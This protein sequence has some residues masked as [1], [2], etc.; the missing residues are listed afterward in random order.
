MATFDL[1]I[2]IPVYN[3]EAYLLRTLDSAAAQS[4]RNFRLI[5]VDNNS[6]DSSPDI[7][8]KFKA[9]NEAADFAVDVISCPTPGAAAARNAGLEIAETEWVYFFDS[10]D[11]MRPDL[12]KKF[13]VCKRNTGAD[14]LFLK[15]THHNPDGSSYEIAPPK[16]NLLENHILHGC[17][18]TMGYLVKRSFVNACGG[19]NA[20]VLGWNDWEL[21]MRLLVAHPEFADIPG[22]SLVDYYLHSDSITGTD[23]SSKLN[24]WL[25]AID[26]SEAVI[27]KSAGSDMN[28]MLLLL[29]YKRIMLAGRCKYEGKSNGDVLYEEVFARL[30]RRFRGL[31]RL[32]Y[33][34][35]A[36]GGRGSSHAVSLAVKLLG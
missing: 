29:E 34:F 19:W 21:G 13:R 15:L 25:Y 31:Y 30:P 27:R 33:A 3:R 4:E 32:V 28:K 6:A 10:D 24:V 36:K 11:V 23:F 1:T 20:G 12:V 5:V 35:I 9:Q 18:R 14:I 26:C 2:I 7:A 16:G 8:R 22:D 17:M